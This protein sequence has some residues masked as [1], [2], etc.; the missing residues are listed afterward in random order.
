MAKNMKTLF[1]AGP[2]ALLVWMY[3]FISASS[4]RENAERPMQ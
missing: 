3:L 2:L 1:P 4:A